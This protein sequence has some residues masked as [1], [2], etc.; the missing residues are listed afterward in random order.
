[1]AWQALVGPALNFLGKT[2]D[3]IPN[4]AK[5]DAAHNIAYDQYQYSHTT[6]GTGKEFGLQN[7]DDYQ[8][9]YQFLGIFFL[10][11]LLIAVVAYFGRARAAPV[12]YQPQQI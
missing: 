9:S 7:L 11:I 12:Y 3:F 5:A 8:E 10:C 2:L 6:V 4:K 1:M